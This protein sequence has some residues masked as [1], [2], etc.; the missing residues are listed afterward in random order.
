MLSRVGSLVSHKRAVN[1]VVQT[2]ESYLLS[3]GDDRLLVVHIWDSNRHRY[4]VAT[5]MGCSNQVMAIGYDSR[6]RRVY[7]GCHGGTVDVF[8]LSLNFELTHLATYKWHGR[9]CSCILVLEH[10]DIVIT[11][12][13]DRQVLFFDIRANQVIYSDTLAKDF[14]RTL[15]YDDVGGKLYL[16]THESNGILVYNL[17]D[18]RSVA[19]N[20]PTLSHRLGAE[21][22]YKHVSPV[23]WID[24]QPISRYLFSCDHDG[25]ILIFQAGEPGNERPSRAIGELKERE[26]T[27][28]RCVLWNQN[29]RLLFSC[30]KDAHIKMW[31]VL[32]GEQIT[33]VLAHRGEVMGMLF[34][35]HSLFATTSPTAILTLFSWGKDGSINIWAIIPK[36]G[37]LAVP[38]R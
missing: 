1:V 30:G 33:S 22:I 11:G 9:E 24:F 31:D 34:D 16:G 25:K 23:R 29:T 13:F 2:P 18:P 37:L 10:H 8:S 26:G 17:E 15:Y 5:S 38:S 6:H 3:G 35:Q 32:K 21:G 36:D 7:T 28:L 14:I 19:N 20:P 4:N 27:K 12:G